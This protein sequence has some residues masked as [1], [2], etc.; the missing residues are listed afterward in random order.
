MM[1]MECP[2]GYGWEGNY[3]DGHCESCHPG[4]YSAS[5]GPTVRCV[6][7]PPGTYQEHSQSHQCISCP[8]W[9]PLSAVGSKSINDCNKWPKSPQGAQTATVEATIEV[10]GDW[11]FLNDML[12][13]LSGYDAHDMSAHVMYVFINL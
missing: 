6:S 10:M 11:T 13:Q 8:E 4:Q 2:D 3:M 5:W 9:S 7:C 1:R 12:E